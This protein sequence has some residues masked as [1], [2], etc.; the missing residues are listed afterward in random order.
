MKPEYRHQNFAT[1][2]A[3]VS[4]HE[5]LAARGDERSIRILDTRCRIEQSRL[6]WRT[7]E[8][9]QSEPEAATGEQMR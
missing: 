7:R 3:F 4:H 1:D 2:E 9:A 8:R 6:I 5:Q